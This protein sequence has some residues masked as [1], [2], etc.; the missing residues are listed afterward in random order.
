M[1]YE[2]IFNEKEKSGN[3]LKIGMKFDLRGSL[4]RK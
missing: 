1:I 4:S 3:D 2:T